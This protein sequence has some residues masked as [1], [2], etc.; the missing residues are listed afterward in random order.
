VARPDAPDHE[1]AL[2]HLMA[3]YAGG[4]L[5][6]WS[7]LP[8]DVAKKLDGVAALALERYPESAMRPGALLCRALAR[9]AERDK[10]GRLTAESVAAMRSDLED[11]LSS[12]PESS[13][14]SFALVGLVRTEAAAGSLGRAAAPYRR[15]VEGHA[16]D[17][18]QLERVRGE[19]GGLALLLGGLPEFAGTTVD[20][21]AVGREALGGKVAVLDFWATWCQPCVEGFE[22]LRRIGERHGEDV[23]LVGVNMDREDDVPLEDLRAWLAREQVPGRQLYDGQSWDSEV[24]RA[25]GVKEIPFTVVVGPDGAV[26]AVDQHGKGLE[27]AVQAA[28]RETTSR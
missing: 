17:T 3:L 14:A 2:S 9:N 5:L 15:F 28:L 10:R 23:L 19:L 27:K 1:L 8:A 11:V 7:V 12:H 16:G 20:G 6:R 22:T 21:A 4:S 24:V 25:F 13:Q 26:V 18:A